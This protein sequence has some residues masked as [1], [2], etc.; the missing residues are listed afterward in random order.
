MDRV[1]EFATNH[2]EM[3][4]AFFGM[5]AMW[6]Y[7]ESRKAGPSI[8]PQQATVIG[9][10]EENLIL[11]IRATADF[12]SGRILN[13]KNIPFAELKTRMTELTKYKE[14]TIVL[15]C[16]TGQTA[17]SASA[18]LKKEGFTDVKRMTGGMAEWQNQGLPLARK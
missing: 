18:L 9:N 4:L 10:D 5:L 2:W 1:I 16:K 7:S 11:D 17:S 3:V 15:V 6:L 13:A 14:H 12:S 8:S